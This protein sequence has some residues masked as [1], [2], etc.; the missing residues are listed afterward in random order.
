MKQ[1]VASYRTGELAVLEVP[2]PAPG[3]G[4]VLV[5]NRSSLVS[6]GTER[7]MLELARKGLVGKARAR[8]D[9]FR[10]FMEKVQRDGLLQ[11]TRAALAR[12]NE[13]FAPGY[14]C[15]GTVVESG[16]TEGA[17]APGDR[18]ACGGLGYASH[19]EYVVVPVNLCAKVPEGVALDAAAF[20]AVGS[21]ALHAFRL[22]G[23]AL[24]ELVAVVG[25]GLVGQLALQIAR[26]AG[27]RTV[28]VEADASRAALARELG[29]EAA[30]LSSEEGVAEKILAAFP[31]GADAV[32][33]C[34]A[35]SSNE[36][37]SLAA[38]IARDR[39]RIVAVGDVGLDIPR[40]EFYRKE[41]SVVVSRS[42]GPGRYDA[43]YE[44]HGLD[45]PP[46]YVRWTE[47]RNFEEFLA[48]VAAGKLTPERLVTHRFPIE[49]AQEAY[50]LVTRGE[51]RCLG[52][53]LEYPGEPSAPARSRVDLGPR[54]RGERLDVL[55]VG[56]VGAGAFAR[57]ILLPAFCRSREVR[58][59]GIAS[60]SGLTA[61]DAGARF[62]FAYCTARVEDILSD[63]ETDAVVIATRHS[64]HAELAARAL[65]AGKA[66]FVEKP[67][68]ID[69]AGLER[70]EEAL[71][72]SRGL[73][74][75]GYNRRFAPLARELRTAL[76]GAGPLA[77]HCTVNAG[78]LPA[79]HW[80]RDPAEGGR[81]VGE[82]GHFVDLMC[83]LCGARP[84]AVFAAGD[85]REEA[86]AT[87]RFADGSVG[88]VAY[89]SRGDASFSKERLEVFAGGAAFVLE[90]FRRLL[91]VRGGRTRTS[92][93][94]QDKGHAAEVAEFVAAARSG[95]PAPVPWEELRAVSLATLA[96][97]ESA[98][99]GAVVRIDG[100]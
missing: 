60:A 99:T 41:L 62:G 74:A 6:S 65:E 34:A 64:T 1:L 100:A 77:M 94:A 83:F 95:G 9:L 57:S 44:E 22:S 79:D 39:A 20:V 72:S 75:V 97:A 31:V 70:V 18:V 37:L 71:R 90:D 54:P 15:A 52:V 8:P 63:A 16:D 68:A 26:A 88:S 82:I 30:Y 4:A 5:R 28:A 53:L 43:G 3:R 14:S 42:Y 7:A 12:L 92:K 29:A 11:A 58:L 13:P 25:A 61:R 40:R 19:A 89:T 84:V 2:T 67:L 47:K 93:A 10:R 23:A 48:L 98:S 27:C 86:S 45:Y 76:A 33:V 32:L 85:G 96:V 69:R 46:G 80:L 78:P 17:F 35:T 59:T 51:G 36:P 73:L 50:D 66:V 81:V 91:A 24:G 49:R 38:A 55:R 87:L 56:F 21:I